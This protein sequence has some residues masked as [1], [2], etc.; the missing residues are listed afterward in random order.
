MEDLNNRQIVLL[1]IFVSFII[2]IGTAIITVAMLE[3]APATITQTVNHVVERT[4]ERIVTGTSTPEKEPTT[5]TNITKEVTVYKKEDD[6]VVSVVEKNLPRVATIFSSSQQASTSEPLTTGFVVSRDGVI[7]IDRSQLGSLDGKE[8]YLV[9]IKGTIYQAK[10]IALPEVD[11]KVAFLKIADT[12]STS[13]DAVSYGSTDES[14]PGQTVVLIGGTDGA[15][16][17]KSTLSRVLYGKTTSTTS[18]Q[19]VVGIETSP[20]IPQGFTGLAINLDGQ[21]IGLIIEREESALSPA[22]YPMSQIL[23]KINLLSGKTEGKGPQP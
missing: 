11:D 12:A 22:I 2:S 5:I 8:K 16:I 6:L 13:L 4:I 10:F 14:K 23:Q 7:V 19:V 3:E 17:F 1:S 20:R 15:S 21:A 18:P 9:E